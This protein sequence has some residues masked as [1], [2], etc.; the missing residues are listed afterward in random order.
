MYCNRKC[1]EGFFFNNWVLKSLKYKKIY[2]ESDTDR[3]KDWA[4]K[5]K[6]SK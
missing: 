6:K 2:I 5:S 4:D 3:K 1:K